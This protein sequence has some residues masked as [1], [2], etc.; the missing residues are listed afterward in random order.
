MTKFIKTKK[1]RLEVRSVRSINMNCKNYMFIHKRLHV[2]IVDGV[3]SA[4]IP[5][6]DGIISITVTEEF[7]SDFENYECSFDSMF[8]LL[9]SLLVKAGTFPF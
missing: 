3:L 1:P 9:A 8:N 2:G 4:Y 6:D 5:W 7:A